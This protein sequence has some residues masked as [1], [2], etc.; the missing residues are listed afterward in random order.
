MARLKVRQET[1]VAKAQWVGGGSGDATREGARQ[2]H[3]DGLCRITTT[4]SCRFKTLQLRGQAYSMTPGASASY[5]ESETVKGSPA[6][7]EKTLLIRHWLLKCHLGA[8]H[9][10]ST[11]I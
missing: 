3:R 5:P 9:I 11:N 1:S 4:T 6:E 2:L 7:A 10:I 8:T